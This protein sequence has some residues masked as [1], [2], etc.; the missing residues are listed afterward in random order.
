MEVL[1]VIASHAE[2]K[3]IGAVI[4]LGNTKSC[5]YGVVK[6]PSNFNATD[7]NGNVVDYEHG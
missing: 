1:N 2:A 7:R 4:D 5:H 6:R 3:S